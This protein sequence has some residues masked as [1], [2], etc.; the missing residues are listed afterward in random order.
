MTLQAVTFTKDMSLTAA[1]NKVMQS[2]T[3]GG[4]VIDE[5]EKVV[6]FLSEQ[7]LLDKLVKA[8]YHCQDTHTVQECMHEDVLS[9]S[10]EMSVIELADMMKVGKPKMY[11]VVDDRGKLVGIITRR[12]VLRAIGMTLNECFKHPV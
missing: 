5:N 4:P 12:D 11:P 9:V 10:P 2:V 1:L 3:L 6:G 7:D 8:S